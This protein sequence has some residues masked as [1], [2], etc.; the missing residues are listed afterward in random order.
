MINYSIGKPYFAL[1][2]VAVILVSLALWN[3]LR[4]LSN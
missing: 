4:L 1:A 2:K 3:N